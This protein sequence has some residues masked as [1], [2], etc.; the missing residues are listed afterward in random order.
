MGENIIKY[1][2][3]Q[4]KKSKNNNNNNKILSKK[5][6]KTLNINKNNNNNNNK[7]LLK[8]K[9]KEHDKTFDKNIIKIQSYIRRFLV[10]N[11]KSCINEDDFY[12]CDTK[13]DTPSIYFF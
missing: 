4:I 6:D 3:S 10:L 2:N 9:E 12:T 5:Y 11:R 1:N 13:Y 7:I 8:E